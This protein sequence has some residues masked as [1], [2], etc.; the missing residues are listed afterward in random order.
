M[1]KFDARTASRAAIID[2]ASWLTGK[3]FGQV[4]SRCVGPVTLDVA[5]KS[6][7]GHLIES[8]FGI[9][10]NSKSEADFVAAGI[11]LKTVPVKRIG[12]KDGKVLERTSITM[13]DFMSLPKE[14]WQRATVRKKLS[15][16]L[17]VFCERD[18]TRPMEEWRVLGLSEWSPA[19]T[20]E[21]QLRADWEYGRDLVR[22]GR[23]EHISESGG[24]I[25]G[26]ATKG[27]GGEKTVPQPFSKVRVR[28]RAWALKASYTRTMLLRALDPMDA[29]AETPFRADGD[30]VAFEVSVRTFL[31]SLEGL[32]LERIAK[33][34]GES[35][36]G[37]KGGN[38]FFIRGLLGAKKKGGRIRRFEELGVEIKSVR[39]GPNLDVF[40]AISFPA[41]DYWEVIEENWEG[42]DLRRRLERVLFIPMHVPYRTTDPSLLR[43]G[44]AFFWSPTEQELDGIAQEWNAVRR[45]IKAGEG[46]LR[47]GAS[48]STYIHTRP[49]GTDSTDKVSAPGGVPLGR[50]SFWLNPAYVRRIM[51]ENGADAAP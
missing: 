26:M 37:G 22:L 24:K 38:A 34:L 45:A 17:F 51:S 11:E 4:L 50:Q 23:A 25:L 3:S 18:R 46:E 48:R 21:P 31:R 9:S 2:R 30:S 10:P 28:P 44:R 33:V 40:E 49:H 41:F 36:P 15:G 7:A 42:S 13:V 47:G 35:V 12:A 27:P 6:T 16:I 1:P 39:L 19:D 5:K 43:L 29:F 20:V 14:E 8:Y 32:S